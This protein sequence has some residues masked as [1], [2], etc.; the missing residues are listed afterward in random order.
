MDS[1]E[2]RKGVAA[3]E[4]ALRILDAFRDD[5][6]GQSLTDLAS[7]TGF[8][9]STI[10]RLAISLE[11]YGYLSRLDN[12]RFVLGPTVFHLGRIYQ[13]SFNLAEHVRPVLQ[14]LVDTHKESATFWIADGKQRICLFR[15]DS[16]QPIRDASVREGD[17]LP[18][19]G[20]ATS[21]VLRA[22]SDPADLGLQ[23]IR[24]TVVAVSLGG[25]IRELAGVSCPVFGDAGKLAGTITI[26]GPMSRF[27]ERSVQRMQASLLAA[28]KSL[29]RQLG[30][31]PEPYQIRAAKPPAKA[32]ARQKPKRR[33]P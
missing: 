23:K 16:P 3:L 20:S 7:K 1:N 21:L 13:R 18:A 8:Y 33:A 28:T 17:R 9:K 31:S 25:F 11:R 6:D 2:T 26:A 4:R 10:L 22:F 19:D 29:T 14:R 27:D 15:V 12:G 32:A 24:D 30:G 5:P